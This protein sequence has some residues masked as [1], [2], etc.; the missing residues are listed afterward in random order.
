MNAAFVP[1]IGCLNL[2]K[3]RC[4]ANCGKTYYS[5]FF[6]TPSYAPVKMHFSSPHKE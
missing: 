2:K 5:L 1:S 4:S 6:S 3:P